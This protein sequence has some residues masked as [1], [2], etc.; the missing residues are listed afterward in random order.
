MY[1]S[2][3]S[4]PSQL[5]LRPAKIPQK[6]VNAVSQRG[7]ILSNTFPEASWPCASDF[8]PSCSEFNGWWLAQGLIWWFFWW[9]MSVYVCVYAWT[10][11]TMACTS[12]TAGVLISTAYLIE[13]G[14]GGVSLN[15]CQI[16]RGAHKAPNTQGCLILLKRT[17]TWIIE[18]MNESLFTFSKCLS[19]VGHIYTLQQTAWRQCWPRLM[20]PTTLNSIASHGLGDWNTGAF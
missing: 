20:V 8:L 10:C 18:W 17:K 14:L 11:I 16:S 15:G 9:G 1:Q 5:L 13:S 6:L 3:F 4:F 12:V 19:D 2:A 7:E